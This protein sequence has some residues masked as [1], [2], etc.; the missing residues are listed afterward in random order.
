MLQLKL[1]SHNS[2]SG[3]NNTATATTGNNYSNLLFQFTSMLIDELTEC[4][5]TTNKISSTA[6][7]LH[8]HKKTRNQKEEQKTVNNTIQ[9]T[10]K[11]SVIKDNN[12]V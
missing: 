8:T 11:Q 7:K 9:L 3:S 4:L 5:M 10:S 1:I 12:S 2:G 6:Q